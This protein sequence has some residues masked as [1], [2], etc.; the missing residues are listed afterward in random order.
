MKYVYTAIFEPEDNGQRI[1]CSVPDLPGCITSG[2]DMD[3]AI[4]MVTDAACLWLEDQEDDGRPVP[5]P[6]PQEQI[7]KPDN[8]IFTLIQADTDEY[9][10]KMHRNRDARIKIP[11]WMVSAAEARGLDCKDV[12]ARGLAVS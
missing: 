11:R 7:H 8:A 1:A 10:R 4:Y 5:T 2:A 3:E 9:R 6:T 12:F